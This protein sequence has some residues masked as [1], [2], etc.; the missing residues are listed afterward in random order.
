MTGGSPDRR[1]AEAARVR[2]R[3]PGRT[4]G[5]ATGVLALAVMFS[6]GMHAALAPE[7]LKEMPPLGWSFIIAAVLGAALACALVT[8]PDDRRLPRLAALFL[9]G[10][11]VVWAVFVTVRVPGFDGTPEA[12]ETIALVCKAAELLGLA[13][14]V[15]LGWPE[16]FAS[17][18]ARRGL[19]PGWPALDTRR[20]GR[21]A[22]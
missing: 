14:A 2:P 3:G 6:A 4:P 10:E 19:K 1:V 13:L 21:S 7:H 20:L 11:M 9:A 12:I 16:L 15:A 5:P 8:S 18:R 22:R 17:R